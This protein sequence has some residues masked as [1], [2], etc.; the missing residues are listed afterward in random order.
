MKNNFGWISEANLKAQAKVIVMCLGGG[1]DAYRLILETAGVES[2]FGTVRDRTINA[3][4]GVCQFDKIPFYDRKPKMMKYRD[5]ILTDLGVDLNLIKWEHL[6]YDSFVSLIMC[7]LYYKII[8]E[9][10][11][12]D[13]EG[14]A[15]Y[16]KKYYNTRAGKGTVEHYIKSSKKFGW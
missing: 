11:P 13:L 12:I 2:K 7:R 5:R 10:L 16:W 9:P 1:D 14:R 8:Q 15:K 6:R 4:I 3:G